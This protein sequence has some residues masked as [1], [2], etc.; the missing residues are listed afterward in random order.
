L[1]ASFGYRLYED[2]L[3]TS[4]GYGGIGT[5]LALHKTVL[6]VPS[7]NPKGVTSLNDILGRG[8]VGMVVVDGNYHDTLTSGTALW[9]DVIGRTG[10]LEDVVNLRGKVCYVA[11]GAGDARNQLLDAENTGCDSWVYW[12]DWAVA[13]PE[14]IEAIELPPDLQIFRDLNVIQTSNPGGSVV[15]DFISFAMNSKEA[16]EAMAKAGWYKNFN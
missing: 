6:L 15:S 8:D 1:L 11:S 14:I 13:N 16:N 10:R 2:I 5:P 12:E 3:D 9:E 4:A 7:G